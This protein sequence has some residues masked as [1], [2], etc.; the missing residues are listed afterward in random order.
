MSGLGD[1]MRLKLPTAC[2]SSVMLVLAVSAPSIPV[3]VTVD[4][5]SAAV[6][7]AEKVSSAVLRPGF[8]L[9]FAVT[10]WG[11]PDAERVTNP[12]S[13]LM[14]IVVP[15]EV[16]WTMLTVSGEAVSV[17]PALIVSLMVQL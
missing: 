16:P 1:A 7:V 15:P 4:C 14:M 17:R 2:T 3:I 6:V 12:F 5:P 9:K 10:P 8:G 13:G 11:N